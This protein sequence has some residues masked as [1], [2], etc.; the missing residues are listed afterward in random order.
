MPQPATSGAARTMAASHRPFADRHAFAHGDPHAHPP[1]GRPVQ[2]LVDRRS[3]MELIT[4]GE[5]NG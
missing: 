4:V 1:F 2:D 3:Q 5:R